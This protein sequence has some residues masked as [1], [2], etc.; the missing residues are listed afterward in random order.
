MYHQLIRLNKVNRIF[1]ILIF[2]SGCHQWVNTNDHQRVE[3]FNSNYADLIEQKPLPNKY[4]IDDDEDHSHASRMDFFLDHFDVQL[5]VKNGQPEQ[6]IRYGVF[7]SVLS[8]D[9]NTFKINQSSQ[10][11]EPEMDMDNGNGRSNGYSRQYNGD[12]NNSNSNG[13][14]RINHQT[15]GSSGS[16]GSGGS[17]D[18]N[19]S[20]PNRN[21]NNSRR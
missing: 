6:A 8:T 14:Y 15:N 7:S 12:N 11:I 2:I 9:R 21:N 19:G 1:P 5:Q 3:N 20:N 18:G 10:T 13:S 16:G 17:A 4:Q